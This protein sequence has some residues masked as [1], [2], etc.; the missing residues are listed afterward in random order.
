[1]ANYTN[2]SRMDPRSAAEKAVAAIGMGYD[3]T[4]DI[5]L[6]ACKFGPNGSRLIEL[7]QS[8]TKE[9]V[10]PGGMEVPNVPANIKCDKGERTRF[11]SDTLSFN[12][13]LNLP[14]LFLLLVLLCLFDI[15]ILFLLSE[16]SYCDGVTT[17][18]F[19]SFFPF[20]PFPLFLFL[21]VT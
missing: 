2:S 7:D 15:R 17:S 1:M 4:S 14:F 6:P 20:C 10:V 3:L 16:S 21:L 19:F 5:R 8:L 12:Q 9:L 11:C 18:C 13:V